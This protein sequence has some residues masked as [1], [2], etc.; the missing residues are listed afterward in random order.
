MELMLRVAAATLCALCAA[1]LIR[2][3]NPELA[4]L[5]SIGSV[6]VITLAALRM[7]TGLGQLRALLQERFDLDETYMQPILK[8]LAVAIVTKLTAELC[9]ENAHAAA[10]AA[11]ELAG[12]LCALGIVMPLLETM[13]KM[14]GDFL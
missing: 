8:C 11:V 6:A 12:S 13:L 1:L 5:L 7:A 9:R 3:K 4:L 14:V 2:Q 10:A